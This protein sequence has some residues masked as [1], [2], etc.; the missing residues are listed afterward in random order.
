MRAVGVE[1]FDGESARGRAGCRGTE[2]NVD[3]ATGASGKAGAAGILP[4]V[5]SAA[6][7]DAGDA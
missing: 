5:K 2:D 7:C 6:G 3:L 4:Q 1:V